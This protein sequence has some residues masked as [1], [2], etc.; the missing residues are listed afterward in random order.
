MGE[1][2]DFVGC[3]A[4]NLRAAARV[5]TRLYDA[6]LAGSGLRIGQVALLAQLRRQPG[7]STSRLAQLLAIERSTV[8]RDVQVLERLG[9]VISEPN[10]HDRRGRQVSLTPQGHQRLAAAAPEWRSAQDLMRARL[11]SRSMGQ[12]VTLA[13]QVVAHG[14]AETR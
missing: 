1:D 4:G 13:Q 14:D 6:R 8:V 10:P 11:G 2:E 5:A 3:L 7:V 9:L 12:L